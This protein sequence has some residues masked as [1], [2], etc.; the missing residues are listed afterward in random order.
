MGVHHKIK[1]GQ[2]AESINWRLWSLFFIIKTIFDK[3]PTI[4]KFTGLSVFTQIFML[5]TTFSESATKITSQILV[6]LKQLDF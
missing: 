4:L 5:R 3:K 1:N 6:S 2:L